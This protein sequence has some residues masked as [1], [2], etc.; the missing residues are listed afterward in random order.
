MVKPYVSDL[1]ELQ[2]N[3]RVTREGEV[4]HWRLGNSKKV[5]EFKQS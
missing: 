2:R 3:I 4:V 5:S 1:P